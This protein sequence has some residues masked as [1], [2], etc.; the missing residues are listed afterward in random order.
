MVEV[1]V[2]VVEVEAAGVEVVEVSASMEVSVVGDS[3]LADEVTSEQ[4]TTSSATATMM[5]ARATR[6]GP[7]ST[8]ATVPGV[9]LLSQDST[10]R[11]VAS[12]LSVASKAHD[13]G[14]ERRSRDVARDGA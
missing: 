10:R 14:A 8:E 11:A 2:E 5:P 6:M 4:A 13:L 7:A 1:E 12:S 9:A 3:S